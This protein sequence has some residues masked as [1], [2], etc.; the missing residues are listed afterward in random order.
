MPRYIKALTFEEAMTLIRRETPSHYTVI[1][2]FED[3]TRFKLTGWRVVPVQNTAHTTLKLN[4]DLT[5][6]RLYQN[7]IPGWVDGLARAIEAATK[8]EV[9]VR[10]GV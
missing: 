4:S 3:K 10:V 8:D 5:V 6:L 1:E 9:K 2:C 7:D